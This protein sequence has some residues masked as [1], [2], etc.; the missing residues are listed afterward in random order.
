MPPPDGQVLLLNPL[1]GK[2]IELNQSI[3]ENPNVTIDLTLQHVNPHAKWR[4]V[5]S[6]C[7]S[8]KDSIK[9]DCLRFS[10]LDSNDSNITVDTNYSKNNELVSVKRLPGKFRYGDTIQVEVRTIAGGVEFAYG[11]EPAV[12]IPL[13]S[14]V[15][16][17]GISCS[18]ALCRFRVTER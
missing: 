4:A 3:S 1:G 9:S 5:A 2:Y 16:T 7:I 12:A 17:L 13:D 14:Q 8:G 6:I 15:E 18:S 10:G 11:D